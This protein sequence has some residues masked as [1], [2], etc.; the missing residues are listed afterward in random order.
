[1]DEKWDD[2]AEG[3][4]QETIE[5]VEE[6]PQDVAIETMPDGTRRGFVGKLAVAAA[7]LV[8]SLFGFA[9]PA[10]ATFR[11]GCCNLCFLPG[12]CTWT[13]CACVWSW[14]CCG[15]P[16]TR[17]RYCRECIMPGYPCIRTCNGVRCSRVSTTQLVC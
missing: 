13:G 1:M 3:H 15:E 7:G 5:V 4:L 14:G 12:T 10:H 16:D 6:H 11:V 8:A 9:Q 2:D 17:F